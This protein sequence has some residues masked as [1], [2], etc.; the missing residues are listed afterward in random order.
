MT[1][2]ERETINSNERIRKQNDRANMTQ[3]G[4]INLREK[5]RNRKI[6]E[7]TINSFLDKIKE[8]CSEICYCCARLFYKEGIRKID[9]T[10]FE[11]RLQTKDFYETI[12]IS[13][14]GS[15]YKSVLQDISQSCQIK[16]CHTCYYHLIEKGNLPCLC[17][18][19]S[20]Y[21]GDIPVELEVLSDIELSL[22]S[23]LKPYMK[24]I[25][26][27]GGKHSQM[28]VKGS[29]VSFPQDV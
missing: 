29:I 28:G 10:K 16:L 9:A 18:S 24:L 23:Q 7:V 20:L 22:V 19:N 4:R 14:N 17:L 12:L 27:R 6:K 26:L 2:E 3:E 5:D 21:P 11:S 8:S 1:Q 15:L 13:N 25:K